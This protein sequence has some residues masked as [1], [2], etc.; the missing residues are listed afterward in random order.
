MVLLELQ[1]V[2]LCLLED[3]YGSLYRPRE[4]ENKICL[5]VCGLNGLGLSS[6]EGGITVEC[7]VINLIQQWERRR[8]KDCIGKKKEGV[9]LMF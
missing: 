2:R 6:L 8:R 7:T 5:W 1:E 4:P 3:L 9:F